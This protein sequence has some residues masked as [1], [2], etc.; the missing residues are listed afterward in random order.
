MS[1]FGESGYVMRSGIVDAHIW[2]CIAFHHLWEK[3][4]CEG[5]G[6]EAEVLEVTERRKG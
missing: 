2:D 1:A 6:N 3:L 5:S 4:Q